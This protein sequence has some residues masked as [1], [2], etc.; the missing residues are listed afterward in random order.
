MSASS[1]LL[2]FAGTTERRNASWRNIQSVAAGISEPSCCT[3][4]R[5]TESLELER[6]PNSTSKW[7]SFLLPLPSI[8]CSY[9]TWRCLGL[10]LPRS[11][12]RRVCTDLRVC[13]Q[14]SFRL[15]ARSNVQVELIIPAFLAL[16][17]SLLVETPKPDVQSPKASTCSGFW[18]DTGKP[19]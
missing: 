17:G 4:D 11:R 8:R 19:M 15:Q 13:A 16:R 2:K 9:N 7:R 1:L 14:F 10:W 5:K 3:L 12:T 6:V 18:E